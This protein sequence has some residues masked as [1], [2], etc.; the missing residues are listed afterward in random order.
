MVAPT[1]RLLF[2][3]TARKL[4]TRIAQHGLKLFSQER[5]WMSGLFRLRLFFIR[6]AL[7]PAD[8]TLPCP[9]GFKPLS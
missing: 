8:K 7:L 6:D 4:E 5:G 9:K 3:R 1:F 2:E